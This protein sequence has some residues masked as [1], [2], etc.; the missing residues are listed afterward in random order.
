MGIHSRDYAREDE[1]D[2]GGGGYMPANADSAIK[3]LLI[4]NVVVFVLQYMTWDAAY[5]DRTGQLGGGITDWLNLHFNHLRSLQAWR[6]VTYGFCHA[7]VQHIFFNM[8]VLWMLGRLVEPIYGKHESLCFFIAAVVVSGLCHIAVQLPMALSTPSAV[9]EMQELI[10]D[11]R[12]RVERG[13]IDE[14]Q[15]QQILDE[16]V[17]R[18]VANNE[19]TPAEIKGLADH[20]R[21]AGVYGASGG[22]MAVTM[23][24]TIHF[25]RLKMLLFMVIPVELRWVM[26]LYVVMDV[27]GFISGNSGVANAAHLGG[28]AFGLLYHQNGW[29]VSTWFNFGRSRGAPS[30][31]RPSKP[32]G[33]GFNLFQ[34][35]PKLKIYD[36]PT[37][38]ANLDTQ[39]DQILTKIHEQG[40]DSLTPDERRILDEASRRYRDRE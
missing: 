20:R 3:L 38:S 37:P 21:L 29:R 32:K 26:V 35:K 27:C 19:L 9:F 18:R 16:E 25:P 30:A 33:T 4:I 24:A 17:A 14:S 15:G 22:V 39:V 34:R 5:F 28:V 36:E 6:L 23:L 13:E 11:T 31:P 8:L 7:N 2:G 1:F 12:E 40:E 10:E